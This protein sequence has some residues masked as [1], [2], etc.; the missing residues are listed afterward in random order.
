[1]SHNQLPSSPVGP[2][3]VG[4]GRCVI[5]RVSCIRTVGRVGAG[6]RPGVHVSVVRG[7]V[8]V[9][10][11]RTATGR[12]GTISRHGRRVRG[13]GCAARWVEMVGAIS[14]RRRGK[15]GGCS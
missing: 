12:V 15:V 7:G 8:A 9:T 11:I 5:I 1:M 14:S 4:I 10:G 2:A 13:V 6:G 3:V